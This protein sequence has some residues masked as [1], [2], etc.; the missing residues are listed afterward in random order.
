MAIVFCGTGEVKAT[1]RCYLE[2]SHSKKQSPQSTRQLRVHSARLQVDKGKLGNL[3][4]AQESSAAITWNA[5]KA[6]E[7]QRVVWSQLYDCLRQH[8][9]Q[10]C[11]QFQLHPVGALSFKGSRNNLGNW[12]VHAVYFFPERFDKYD[13][14]MSA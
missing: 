11:N 4:K 7:L 12:I 8:S 10:M 5:V 13:G 3:L 6:A 9:D 14:Y 1:K 2:F